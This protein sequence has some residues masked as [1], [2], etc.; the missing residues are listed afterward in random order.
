MPA[1]VTLSDH[2]SLADLE[3]RSRACHAPV[4]RSRWHIVWLVGQGHSGAAVAR[5]TSYSET[6]VRALVHRDNDRGPAG[7][8]DGRHAHPGRAPLVPLDVRAQLRDALAA[9]PP[10][11]GVW[12][13]PKA[14]VWLTDRI[15]RPISPQR[16][17]EV[18]RAVGVTLQ[19]PR[20]HAAK[21]DP[22]AQDA[23]KNGAR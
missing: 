6:W 22:A 10:D 19:R 17:W 2:L 8:A 18:L 13:G 9:P 21:A 11:G 15:D 1:R 20:P 12:T 14:A 16:A 4:E 7:L 23:F 3:R 5:L